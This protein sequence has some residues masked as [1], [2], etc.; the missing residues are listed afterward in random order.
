MLKY[1]IIQLDDTSASFCHYPTKR[2]KS[3]IPL[4]ALKDGVLW[5]LKENL[6]VQFVYPD[7]ELPKDYLDAIDSIDHI[8]IAHDHMK[9]DVSIFDGEN[10]LSTL[11]TSV[12][13]HAILRVTKDELFNNVLD[14][15][16]ALE[17][18]TSLNIVITDVETFKDTD[19]ESYK[20]VLTELSSI[21]EQKIV[22]N[23]QVNINILTDRLVL[24]S[25][26][27]CNAGVESITLA[28]DGNFYICPA[29]YYCEEECVGNPVN[30][31]HIPNEQLYK[32]EY[33]PICRICD[34]FQCKRCVWL[35]KQ[36][37]G[38]VNSK[39]SL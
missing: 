28:P 31:L 11:K 37:T 19:F 36:T 1:L 21:V 35:N 25:M 9:A 10:S 12:F 20:K 34:A 38:E 5:A 22:S 23:K 17:K 8:D 15:K 32:L 2:Q 29:S 16:E 39:Q 4:E 27:N 24:S 26:N 18:Q 3:L 33:S 13:T 30:G 14:V 6:M 7:Y